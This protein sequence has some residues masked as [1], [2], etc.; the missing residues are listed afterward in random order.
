MHIY[1]LVLL[2]ITDW[3]SLLR[4]VA[5]PAIDEASTGRCVLFLS[6]R[7]NGEMNE[8]WMEKEKGYEGEERQR[9]ESVYWIK[10]IAREKKRGRERKFTRQ[11]ARTNGL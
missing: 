8:Y 3:F 11:A 2:S 10:E 6:D 9:K 1:C 5:R 4:F 7:F